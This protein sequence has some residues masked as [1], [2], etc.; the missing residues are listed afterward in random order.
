[1]AT[2]DN[3]KTFLKLACG[4]ALLG[5][6]AS[7]C[8]QSTFDYFVSDAGGGNSL[9]T[10][11]A[12][13]S[14]TTSPGAVWKST[15]GDFGGLSVDTPGIYVDSYAGSGQFQYIPTPDGS[16]FHNSELNRNF[17]IQIYYTQN[18]LGGSNDWFAL[19]S[20]ASASAGQHIIYNAGTQSAIIPVPFS[21]FNPGTYQTI[22]ATGTFLDT[23]TTVNLTVI[24]APEPSTMALSAVGWL[25]V[26][27]FYRRR[28]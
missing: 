15:G 16:Y 19:I 10:W 3:M 22:W 2:T 4:L 24:P 27:L 13:G 1:M 14:I 6:V 11:D 18:S 21:D 20:L 28:K 8:G 26:W 23:T 5:A 25:G 17:P 12:S 7:A 9:V